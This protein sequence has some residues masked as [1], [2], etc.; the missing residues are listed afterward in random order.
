MDDNR[1]AQTWFAIDGNNSV[2]KDVCTGDVRASRFRTRLQCLSRK[3]RPER[4]IV[5]FDPDDSTSFR[6]DLFPSY[7]SKRR[8]SPKPDGLADAIEAA[9]QACYDECVDCVWVSGFEADDLLATVVN[10]ALSVDRRCCLFSSDKDLRQLLF[11]G[12]INQCTDL[13]RS[14]HDFAATWLKA[15]DMVPTFGVLAEQWIDYQTLV[16]DSS[17]S[18]PGVKGIGHDAAIEI[19]TKCKTIDWFL[20]HSLESNL[21]DSKKAKVK[22]ARDD[23]TLDLMRELVT[24]RSDV[25]I[26]AAMMELEVPA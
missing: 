13:K 24:L 15:D 7:K 8:Q 9:K 25:T 23:G 16:G 14:G 2:Y 4:I 1:Y 5:A 17:D 19:L 6:R 12:R 26:G 22:A 21:S 20:S 18:I 10:G 3:W 11:P